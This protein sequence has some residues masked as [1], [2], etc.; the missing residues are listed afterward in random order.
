MSS[1]P[2]QARL[3]HQTRQE[4]ADSEVSF[5][6]ANYDVQAGILTL[7]NG[8]ADLYADLKAAPDAAES[9]RLTGAELRK[10]LG[11][12]KLSKKEIMRKCMTTAKTAAGTT[13]SQLV[14]YPANDMIRKAAKNP[15][16]RSF[17]ISHSNGY[18]RRITSGYYSSVP[19]ESILETVR[20][21]ISG[22]GYTIK[23]EDTVGPMISF[24]LGEALSE[25]DID[26]AIHVIHRNDGHTALKMFT[27]GVVGIC[28][29]GMVFGEQTSK[30]RLN[31][32]WT[33]AEVSRYI[34]GQL[35]T[36][37]QNMADIPTRLA[38]LK[39]EEITLKVAKKRIAMLPLA[40]FVIKAV[41]DRLTTESTETANGKMDFDGTMYGVYMA[42]TYVAS[43]NQLYQTVRFG[44]RPIPLSS[45]IQLADIR[46]Y[47][48]D[49]DAREKELEAANA[50]KIKVS[51]PKAKSS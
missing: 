5:D 6:I 16:F 23:S 51:A 10:Y 37:V 3:V 15:M 13:T 18:V 19:T 42:G 47:T 28:T 11:Y 22:E 17:K 35:T 31:H 26:P 20:N 43:H 21:R 24:R 12:L 40:P 33:E 34:E 4:I 9:Y 39:E 36:L 30:G 27:G 1:I 48:Q 29:N 41:N 32:M 46:T 8:H 2:E 50:E 44:K 14:A 25:S 38:P 45:Q 7:D 49:W